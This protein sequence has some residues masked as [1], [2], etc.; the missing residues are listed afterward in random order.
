[1]KIALIGPGI[2]SIPPNNWG[3][4]E[5]LIWDYGEYLSEKGL[6]VDIINSPNMND[7]STYLNN[8][9]YDFIH[10][11]YDNHAL[12]LNKLC[13]KPFCTTT[14]YGYI[15]EHYPDYGGW[16]SVFQGVKESSGIISLSHEIQDIFKKSGYNKFTRV[17]RNGA[18]TKEFKFDKNP[19][20]SALCLGKIEI[21]KKQSFLSKICSG[22]CYIDFFGP[23]VDKTFSENSTCK[24]GG[25]WEKKDLYENMT[26]YKTLVLL[27]DGEAAPLVV[28]EALSSGLSLVLTKTAAANL[29]IDLP[30]IKVLSDSPTHEEITESIKNSIEDNYLYRGEIR[31]Y[32]LSTFDWGVICN[33]YIKIIEEFR[34]E[35]CNS[36]HSNQ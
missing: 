10:V 3:A 36:N 2:M 23:I 8:T 13:K 25:I 16:N 7:V 11:Q 22:K 31:D 29:D 28:P 6:K 32:A 18:R 20:K 24:Y 27:S 1:M 19:A 5:S 34:N 12:E 4:V 17:L 9:H 14:H 33:D 26:N 30:F 35:N 21:R 15:K